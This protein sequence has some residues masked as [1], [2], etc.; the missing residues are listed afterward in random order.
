MPSNTATK[1]LDVAQ[2]MVRHRGYSAFSYA[3]ISAEVGIKKASI[4]YH[5]PS[6]EDLVKALVV[7]YRERLAQRCNAISRGTSTLREK[8]IEFAHLYLD[9]L[10]K[11]QICL[12]AM[13]TADYVVLPESI[14]AEITLF[15]AQA[16]TWLSHLI[17]QGLDQGLWLGASSVAQ[18]AQ[19]L[20]A[21]LQGAQ[22]M[23]RSSVNSCKTFEAVVYPLIEAKILAG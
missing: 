20:I 17:Q 14:Q 5:F 8:V 7:R 21:M 1:I 9:G 10:E 19:G 15:F 4:H 16:E 2:A 12:C 3:D 22:L 18:E 6:K 11:D 23:A 13:L